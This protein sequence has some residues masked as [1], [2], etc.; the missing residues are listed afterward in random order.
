M[1]AFDVF[2]R[3]LN[4]NFSA[5]VSQFIILKNFNFLLFRFSFSSFGIFLNICNHNTNVDQYVSCRKLSS[6]SADFLQHKPRERG[7]GGTSIWGHFLFKKRNKLMLLQNY[8]LFEGTLLKGAN[9][10]RLTTTVKIFCI[11]FHG[12]LDS[13]LFFC[14]YVSYWNF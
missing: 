14:C 1:S 5:Y 13:S 10:K 8:S 2:K 9:R 3:N 6:K 11:L 4:R 12:V 7:G